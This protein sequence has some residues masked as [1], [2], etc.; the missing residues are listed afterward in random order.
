[1]PSIA[2][3]L[4]AIAW[5]TAVE[6]PSEAQVAPVAVLVSL[7]RDER[8][9]VDCVKPPDQRTIDP[10][11]HVRDLVCGPMIADDLGRFCAQAGRRP[12]VTSTMTDGRC[13][14]ELGVVR[15]ASFHRPGRTEPRTMF[16]AVGQTGAKVRIELH[17]E[18]DVAPGDGRGTP[19][20]RLSGHVYR[21]DWRLAGTEPC[22][23]HGGDPVARGLGII[24]TSD[25]GPLRAAA[26][27]MIR[28]LHVLSWRMVYDPAAGPVP[29]PMPC[30]DDPVDVMQRY[31]GGQ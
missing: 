11:A 29:E 7:A 22:R 10:E 31:G 24:L 25:D 6:S 13:T 18:T 4:P 8:V 3:E 1:M 5:T 16:C 28:R 12:G 30:L 27:Q 20:P 14:I 21:Y 2:R 19:G 23:R 9:L 17:D 26:E 15:I